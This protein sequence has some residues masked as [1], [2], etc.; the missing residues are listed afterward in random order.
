[1]EEKEDPGSLTIVKKSRLEHPRLSFEQIKKGV[2]GR[3][4]SLSLVFIGDKASKKLNEKYRKTP[5]PASVLSF[6]LSS[7]EGEIFI[8]LRKARDEANRFD[9]SFKEFVTYLFIHGMLHL[10]GMKHGCTMEKEERRLLRNF[11]S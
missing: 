9:M 3:D 5:R 10:K 1:M 6:P 11:I 8:N 2:L 7:N 4:Y